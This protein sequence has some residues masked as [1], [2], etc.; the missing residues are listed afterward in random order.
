MIR[1]CLDSIHYVHTNVVTI[2]LASDRNSG[3]VDVVHGDWMAAQ[4]SQRG[5]KP[6]FAVLSIVRHDLCGS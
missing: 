2:T 6:L 1:K 4:S 5:K 3:A